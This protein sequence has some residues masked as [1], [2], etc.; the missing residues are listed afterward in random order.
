VKQLICLTTNYPNS[1]DWQRKK[2]F[3][4]PSGSVAVEF[5]FIL[6]LFLFLLFV[7]IET[8]YIALTNIVIEGA[9][10]TASRE[11]RTGV[12]Q[13]NPDPLG[14]FRSTLC[15]EVNLVVNC[16]LVRIDVQS[17]GTFPD[18]TTIAPPGPA[19]N[20]NPGTADQI[21]LVRVTHTW[22]YITPFLQALIGPRGQQYVASAIF[23]V[24]P[25]LQN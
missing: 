25:F 12:V 13:Q 16:N 14:R 5:A 17:F 2:F 15:D 22:N 1:P 19:D 6:P 20:F 9:V 10:S 24:E 7:V 11:I 4:C 3:N 23:K 18:P 21:T 8:G